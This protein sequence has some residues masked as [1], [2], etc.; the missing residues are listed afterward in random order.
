MAERIG[1][2]GNLS[3]NL[4]MDA[5]G[6][7]VDYARNVD[8][9]FMWLY[10][11]RMYEGWSFWDPIWDA[12]SDDLDFSYNDQ[13]DSADVEARRKA[14]KPTLTMNQIPAYINHVVGISRQSKSSIHVN[15]SSG[16]SDR[17]PILESPN[18]ESLDY[19]QI[20]DGIIR[21]IERTSKAPMAYSRALQHA[22]EG[23]IGWL[24]VALK[25]SNMDPR[26]IDLMIEHIADRYSVMHDPAGARDPLFLDSKWCC[27]TYL[28]NRREFETRYP[29]ARQVDSGMGP[30]MEGHGD[31]NFQGWW[32]GMR[33][34]VR[35]TDYWYREPVEKRIVTYI[36]AQTR[37]E[38]WGS[39]EELAD[40]TD[41]LLDSNY[42]LDR[43]ED[44]TVNAIK[45]CVLTGHEVLKPPQDWPSMLMPLVPVSGRQ[46]DLS[47]GNKAYLS[48][49]RYGKDPQRMFNSWASA[50]TERLLKSP[51]GKFLA[52]N[53]MVEDHEAQWGDISGMPSDTLIYNE[54][55]SGKT[56]QFIGNPVAIGPE[57][58]ATELA[59]RTL[60]DTIGI[61]EASRGIASNETSGRAILERREAGH[62]GSFEFQDNQALAVEQV[63]NILCDMIPR[64]YSED[65]VVNL[66]MPDD[67]NV[68]IHINHSIVDKKT[69]KKFRVGALGLSRYEC[70]SRSGPNIL[71]E[72]DRL[73]EMM[74]EW[75]KNDP[76]AMSVVRDLVVDLF[77]VP[78][79]EKI[80]RRFK[81]M[82]PPHMLSQQ[83]QAMFPPQPPTPE[84]EVEKLKAD[85]EG[86]RAESD[87]EISKINK[88]IAELKLQEAQANAGASPGGGGGNGAG[89]AEPGGV[90]IAQVESMVE[91]MVARAMA[92][93]N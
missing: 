88:D 89:M 76:P 70:V 64:V 46:V 14:K 26:R 6:E 45:Y 12:M 4:V 25:R 39:E 75:G 19:G 61:P 3:P 40:F 1:D 11:Q 82:L 72:K 21:N 24:L 85:A 51:T 87:L 52:S 43:E 28:M 92:K 38:V 17:V 15:R 47:D 74:L 50:V 16:I 36:N 80:V 23:G 31:T 91:T 93:K 32:S 58:Q 30:F 71:T 54:V 86:A 20:M 13:W 60:V 37:D 7:T 73:I 41:E 81:K 69:G 9:Q 42:E 63:G 90:D 83:E 8:D 22:V 79:A 33:D 65:R 68:K 2:G 29:Q 48:L 5:V 35:V 67:S 55:E 77:D 56:P 53:Q 66:V 10:S 59:R 18:G 62:I 49:P 44:L 34:V 84:Q 27:C 78:G 57:L